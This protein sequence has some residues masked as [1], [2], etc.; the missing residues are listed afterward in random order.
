MRVVALHLDKR[1]SSHMLRAI[2]AVIVLGASYYYTNSVDIGLMMIAI[3]CYIEIGYI[4]KV[5]LKLSE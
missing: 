4:K 3:H 5:V 2:G 1:G